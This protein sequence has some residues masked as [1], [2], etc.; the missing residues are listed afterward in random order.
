VTT[1]APQ[2]LPSAGGPLLPALALILLG[3]LSLGAGALLKL[4]R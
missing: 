1:T 2:V 3:G 4:S